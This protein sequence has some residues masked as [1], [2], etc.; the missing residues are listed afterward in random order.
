MKVNEIFA[1]IEGEGSRAGYPSIFIRLHGCNLRCSYCDSM[2][3]V[4]GDDFKE[5]K[6][7]EILAEVKKYNIPRIT[8]TGGEPLIHENV[9]ELIRELTTNYSVNIETNGAVDL[10][11]FVKDAAKHNYRCNLMFT[12]DWKSLSSNMHTRMIQD[13][14]SLLSSNDVLKFVV[15]SPRDLK[16][17]EHIVKYLHPG[18]QVFI[19]PIFGQIE[20]KQIVEYMLVTGMNECR[21]QLQLHKFIWPPETKGV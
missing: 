4:S 21:V 18:C 6:I 2:Y 5:M 19:S 1:S 3:A 11:P 16:Q 8:L 20:P 13:N 9:L 17:A 14:V 7:C 10:T 12:M 15:G